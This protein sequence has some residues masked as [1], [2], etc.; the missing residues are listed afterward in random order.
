MKTNRQLLRAILPISFLAV[1]ACEDAN[2]PDSLAKLNTTA[3]L[4]D[5]AALDAIRESAGWRGFQMAA[6]KMAARTRL[7]HGD[8]AAKNIPLISD[9]HRGKTF[10]YDA[11]KHDWVIDPS[12][13]DAP[14]NGVRFITYQPNGSEP[15]PTRPIGH[16]DLI[17]LGN[18]SAGIALRLIVTE[19]AM[20]ILDYQTAVE[21]GATGGHV[22]VAGFIQNASDKLDFDID[23][24][25][26]NSGGIERGDITFEIG[27]ASREFRVT[28]DVEGE[29][30]AGVESGAVDLTVR[31]G[32][33]S[34]HV[35]V[36][37]ERGTLDGRISLNSSPFVILSG[38]AQQPV[39]KTAAGAEIGGAEA[40][41]LGRVFD[42]TEDVFDLF[43]DLIDPIDDLVMWAAIL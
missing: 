3:A 12:R 16:A 25:G 18:T 43:E 8:V 7:G 31:H 5:Y 29:K 14:A 4:A 21:G 23:V 32:T 33:S 38:T 13:T 28:G 20:M 40:L 2:G 36:E 37:N 17:D 24:T 26:Q 41:L 30:Q 42:V 22:T 15:D 11:A 34:F 6:P 10:V 19:G 27:I 35:D 1:T 39:F 9:A